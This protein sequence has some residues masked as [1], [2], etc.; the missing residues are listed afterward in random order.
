MLVTILQSWWTIIVAVVFIGIV[1]WAYTPS[2][3]K[4][5]EDAG[6]IPFEGSDDVIENSDTRGQ[7]N[8]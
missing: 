2:H 5:F 7:K 3:K 4:E 6:N 8:V 1:I